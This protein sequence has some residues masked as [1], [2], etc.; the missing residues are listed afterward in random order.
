MDTLF[1]HMEDPLSC[2]PSNGWWVLVWCWFL[3]GFFVWIL[4][5]CF[6][7]GFFWGVVLKFCCCCCCF[8]FDFLE[9]FVVFFAVVFVAGWFWFGLGFLGGGGCL[10]LFRVF[11][12]LFFLFRAKILTIL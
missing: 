1:N 11:W 7:L 8:M 3:L 12:V 4:L 10:F 2:V 9:R 6:V 5:P